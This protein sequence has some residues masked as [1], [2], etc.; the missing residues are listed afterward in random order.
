MPNPGKPAMDLIDRYLGAIRFWLPEGQRED[1]L[2]ELA[3]D[4]RSQVADR[5]ASLNRA[6][7]E[8]ELAAFLKERGDPMAVASQF[9][10]EP[11]LIS[12]KLMPGYWF[13]LK[14]VVLWILVPVFTVIVAA[15]AISR[16]DSATLAMLKTGWQL[17]CASVFTTGVITIVFA[18]ISRTPSLTKDWDPRQ[19][20]IVTPPK[21]ATTTIPRST[22]IAEIVMA[23]LMTTAWLTIPVA[24]LSG[25]TI[26]QI[27][28]GPTDAWSV[29]YW[30]MLP[31]LLSGIPL[32]WTS[33]V[34]PTRTGLRAAIRLAVNA[35]SLILIAVFLAARPLVEVTSSTLSAGSL[36]R[37]SKSINFA[38][39]LGFAVLACVV[40]LDCATEV[41]RFVRNRRPRPVP[42]LA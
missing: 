11:H 5:E 18:I 27:H 19:L 38:V 24:W 36:E 25:F 29:I 28:I 14:L 3:D 1:I 6:L 34:S 30:L 35:Y 41:W 31:S 16:G 2:A 42:H 17:L 22:A 21:P 23:I 40:A 13:V 15:V 39:T 26:D 12:P 33:L 20:P 9:Q 10:P 7:T 37:A 4:L 32:G 8:D